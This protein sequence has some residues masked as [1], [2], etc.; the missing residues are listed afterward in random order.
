MSVTGE[1]A[2]LFTILHDGTI[3][4][5]TGNTK[6]LNLKISCQYLAEL[7]NPSFEY[8]YIQLIEIDFI[9]LQTFKNISNF[10]NFE[11]TAVVLTAPSDI[12]NEEI[13]LYRAE[14]N[15]GHV[16]INCWQVNIGLNYIANCLRLNCE[17]FT[18]QDHDHN[19]IN[20]ELLKNLKANHR[21]KL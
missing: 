20:I 18:V 19:L 14:T 11:K 3:E 6:K 16:E 17:R 21:H 9:E 5:F 7:I 2:S 10:E 12:F 15:N 8:F 13:D 1:L 4:S